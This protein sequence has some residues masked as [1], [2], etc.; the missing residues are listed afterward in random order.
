MEHNCPIC[1]SPLQIAKSEFVM[2][3]DNSPDIPTKLYSK[4]T[5]VCTNSAIDPKTKNRLC[6]N[7]CGTDLNNP[8]IVVEVIKNP[9]N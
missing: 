4:L 7:Y 3:G 1:G 8:D 5:M 2:E 9:L 6:S